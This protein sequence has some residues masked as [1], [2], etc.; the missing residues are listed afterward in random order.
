MS[1]QQIQFRRA[2][3]S[4]AQF[5]SDLSFRSKSHWPYD[6]EYLE[7]CRRATHVTADNIAEWPFQVAVEQKEIR[8]FS[9]VCL[10]KGERMLD[11]LWLEPSHIG[12]GLG[13]KLFGLSVG[14]AVAM[15]WTEFTIAADPYAEN[16]YLK[17]GAVRV[18]ERESK[19][20]PGFF[21][22]LLK[23]TI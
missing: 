23:Y 12:K 21:L 7:M 1:T 6:P 13:R 10:V 11:H 14:D 22:P 8:G 16:F 9:A 5:L 3:E 19:I 18:G 15:G 2:F 17:M 20:K 4:E